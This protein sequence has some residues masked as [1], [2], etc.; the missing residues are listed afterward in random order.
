MPTAPTA[1]R[2]RVRPA[3]L[4]TALALA[5]TGCGARVAEEPADAKDDRAAA[6]YPVTVTNCGVRTTYQQA[7]RRV[8]TNDVGITEIMFALGLEDRMAGYVMP[9]DKGDLTK[10]PW[11]AAYDEVPWLS[12]KAITKEIALDAKADLVFAGW[13]YGFGEGSGVTP[14]S[15]DKLG[16]G[17][18]VLTESCH[19]GTGAG[20]RGVMPPLDAL[21]T[22]LAAL[23]KLFDVEDRAQALIRSYKKQVADAAAKVPAH[24]PTVFLY[25]DGRDK[26]LTAGKYAAP[27][28]IITKA[29]GDH[30]M[31][32]LKDSWTTVGWETVVARDPDVIVI[33][34]YGDTTAAQKKAFLESYA[35]LANVSAVKHHRIYVMDYAELVESPRNPTAISD[36][37]RYLRGVHTA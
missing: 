21:Y 13:N 24:R 9:D 22:D 25:D 6:H 4:L 16:I 3:A 11:K 8:V 20:A 31:K 32:D 18:Y 7:P 19:N 35:P 15:L 23:G 33:N 26:P 37:A 17:S 1:T 36:L 10:V 30:V 5:L 28:D 2:R 12:K 34:N 29:G 27:H 14:A